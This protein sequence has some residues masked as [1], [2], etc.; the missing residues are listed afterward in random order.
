MKKTLYGVK[1]LTSGLN[2]KK[3]ETSKKGK[4]KKKQKKKMNIVILNN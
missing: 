2:S 4:R 1:N 3:F